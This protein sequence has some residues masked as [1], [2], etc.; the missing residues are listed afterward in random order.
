MFKEW[1]AFTDLR[2]ILQKAR[3]KEVIRNLVRACEKR[4]IDRPM[5]WES[6]YLEL[7]KEQPILQE[8][9]DIGLSCGEENL[10]GDN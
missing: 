9:E 4:K 3:S 6:Y 8:E 10:F 7:Y 1:T 5:D 2:E